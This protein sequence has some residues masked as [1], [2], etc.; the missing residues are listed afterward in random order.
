M[1]SR[2]TTKKMECWY[3]YAI[4]D[5]RADDV[6]VTSYIV[7]HNDRGVPDT[8][9]RLVAMGF[10]NEEDCR[11]LLLL[12]WIYSLAA[13]RVKEFYEERLAS[14]RLEPEVIG[15]SANPD[16]IIRV[17]LDEETR[18]AELN[19]YYIE[20]PNLIKPIFYPELAGQR[21]N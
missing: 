13:E 10:K 11:E 19:Y 17:E 8:C 21:E 1:A 4:G 15:E 18:T 14:W 20:D 5:R 9:I 2:K 7:R 6:V 16:P 3:L 12:G